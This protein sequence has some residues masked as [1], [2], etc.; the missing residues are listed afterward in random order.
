MVSSKKE[1]MLASLEMVA[2]EFGG[3][4]QYMR[5][6]CGMSDEGIEQLKVNLKGR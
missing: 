2:K 1:N 4:E 3:A 5:K 6:N